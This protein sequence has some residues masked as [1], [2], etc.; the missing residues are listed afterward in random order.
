MAIINKRTNDLT[1]IWDDLSFTIYGF[2]R[3]SRTF[4]STS[5]ILSGLFRSNQWNNR[6][7]RQLQKV[8]RFSSSHFSHKDLF[9]H[10]KVR[11]IAF[12]CLEIQSVLVAFRKHNPLSLVVWKLFVSRGDKNCQFAEI[13]NKW[14]FHNHFRRIDNDE[15]HRTLHIW[16]RSATISIFTEFQL[17]IGSLVPEW[18]GACIPNNNSSSLSQYLMLYPM[19]IRRS[20]AKKFVVCIYIPQKNPDTF[21]TRTKNSS[22]CFRV[23]IFSQRLYVRIP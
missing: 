11:N 23:V 12:I 21:K 9:V 3:T 8:R 22:N 15:A 17:W 6:S 7:R 1:N 16:V 18:V 14:S 5:I 13:S 19:Y 20:T 2:C 4:R 10:L